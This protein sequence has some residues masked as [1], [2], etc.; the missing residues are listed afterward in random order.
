MRAFLYRQRFRL[1][2]VAALVALLVFVLTIHDFLAISRPI[3]GNILVVE[4]WIYDSSAI[5][6]AASEFTRGH[7][8]W[9]ITVGGPIGEEGLPNQENSAVLA[10]IKL[11]ELGVDKSRIV[12]LPVPDVTSHRTYASALT[13]RDWL[14]RSK[15]EIIGINI[16]TLGAH[17]RKSLLLFRRALGPET[18]IGVIAGTE[19][20][21]DQSHWWLSS[22]GIYVTMRKTLGYLYAVFWPIPE[23]LSLPYNSGNPA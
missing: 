22:R 14:T 3:V 2:W 21:Y 15:T 8:E 5:K 9:L 18:N 17:A 16:F 1:P 19:D 12:E 7:Y 10:A 23:G 11:R 20:D 13:L 6:E 4:A